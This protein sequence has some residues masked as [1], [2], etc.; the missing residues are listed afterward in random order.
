[1]APVTTDPFSEAK[2]T[3]EADIKDATIVEGYVTIITEFAGKLTPE[4]IEKVAL[5]T[6]LT[7]L[8]S[9]SIEKLL[10]G[11]VTAA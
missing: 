6:L 8:L 2:V 10:I 3:L 5:P 1:M 4:L 7:K 9:T 11:A